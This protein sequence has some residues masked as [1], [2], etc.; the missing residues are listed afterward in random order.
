MDNTEQKTTSKSRRRLYI[1]SAVLLVIGCIIYFVT[2]GP[3]PGP[4]APPAPPSGPP[5]PSGTPASSLCNY[6]S[7][8]VPSSIDKSCWFGYSAASSRLLNGDKF[9]LR[10]KLPL[11][12]DWRYWRYSDGTAVAATCKHFGTY[13]G[14]DDKTNT[15]S[16]KACDVSTP[17]LDRGLLYTQLNGCCQHDADAGK[18]ITIPKNQCLVHCENGTCSN[19]NPWGN[20]CET[21]D[22]GSE[23]WMNLAIVPPPTGTGKDDFLR[24]AQVAG[25]T[26]PFLYEGNGSTAWMDSSDIAKSYIFQVAFAAASTEESYIPTYYDLDIPTY[27]DPDEFTGRF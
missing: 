7:G 9:Y 17:G 25:I 1:F 6:T 18:Y 4:P 14:N 16:F 23:D 5:A 10:G 24:I 20:P 2:K 26:T 12:D 13:D 15:F 19:E 8:V 22:D 11:A 21:A 27:Y 3:S